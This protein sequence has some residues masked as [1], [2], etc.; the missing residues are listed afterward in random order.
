MLGPP[1][2]RSRISILSRWT[3]TTANDRQRLVHFQ[4]ECTDSSDFIE[5]I[6]RT[7]ALRSSLT[8]FAYVVHF[9]LYV[10]DSRVPS[11]GPHPIQVIISETQGPSSYSISC[12]FWNDG[13]EPREGFL[14]DFRA[15]WEKFYPPLW[16]RPTVS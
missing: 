14:E 7:E 6:Q 12:D 4:T 10:Q 13:E 16:G 1:P 8:S 9:R 3:P 2:K 11:W 5:F 15:T